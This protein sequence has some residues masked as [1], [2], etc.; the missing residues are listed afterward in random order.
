[1]SSTQLGA[2]KTASVQALTTDQVVALT[3]AQM[4]QLTTS[5]LNALTSAQ[6]QA[7]ETT[8]IAALTSTQLAGLATASVQMLT[9][10]QVVALTTT[11]ASTLTTT[12][13]NALTSAQVR[14]LET[15]DLQALTTKQ[16]SGLSS[17]QT[18]VLSTTQVESWTSAQIAALS[19]SAWGQLD[20]SGTPIILDLNGDGVKTLSINSGVKFDLFAQGAAINTGWVSSGDGLLVLDRNHDGQIND[21]SELFGSATKL[22]N[23]Q[24]APDGYAAL[25]EL[26]TNHDGVIDSKDAA[27]ND[28]KVWVD[29]NSDG[30][31]EGGE[32]HSLASL[33]IASVNTNAQVGSATDNG[34]ILG[35]TS[36]YQTTDGASHNAADVWFLANKATAV[37]PA[38][39]PVVAAVAAPTPE[40]TLAAAMSWPDNAPAIAATLPVVS[41]VVDAAT[42]ALAPNAVVNVN[43]ANAASASGL[44]GNVSALAQAIGSFTDSMATAGTPAAGTTLTPQ[45]AIPS[46]NSPTAVAVANMADVMKQFDANGNAIGSAMA[47]ASPTT[48]L[49]LPG[50]VNPA[51]N[52]LLTT[53]GKG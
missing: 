11:Q 10:D 1:L 46:V 27:F 22:A 35:L 33:N 4:S 12:V 26:D 17:Q 49:T 45:S 29:S 7:I 44:R 37:A 21:G 31:T 39:P 48:S 3:T 19:T 23:G 50:Q 51:N 13:L 8:D 2:L 14:A 34:N 40:A 18:A 47:A 30:V 6:V 32:L 53:G 16:I 15:Q 38:V 42:A 5:L 43:S 36:T 41:A 24:T 28:L 52:G 9:T 20:I 25:R